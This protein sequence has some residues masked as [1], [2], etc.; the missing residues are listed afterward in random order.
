[1]DRG[2]IIIAF[3]NGI[4]QKEIMAMYSLKYEE[5]KTILRE[6]GLSSKD[7]NTL[8]D[9]DIL[10]DIFKGYPD[11]YIITKHN[12]T[13]YR[14]KKVFQRN[15]LYIEDTYIH[16]DSRIRELYKSGHSIEK[17][18]IEYGYDIDLM[19]SILKQELKEETRKLTIQDYLNRVPV[20][21]IARTYKLSQERIYQYLR[22][23][24]VI[25]KRLKQ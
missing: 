3:L 2:K 12:I 11:N 5:L 25:K 4:Q 24:G 10:T 15:N 23:A 18:S 21:E 7:K 8:Q 14:Y 1:M 13:T 9:Q 16:K 22:E 19:E 17:L 6:E 20:K